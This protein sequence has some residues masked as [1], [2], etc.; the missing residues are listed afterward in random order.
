MFA[1]IELYDSDVL[2]NGKY[3]EKFITYIVPQEHR[4]QLVY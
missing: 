4:E 3:K 1:A 2:V